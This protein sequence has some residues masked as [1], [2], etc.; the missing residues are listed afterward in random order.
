MFYMFCA[1]PRPRY[2]VS[3]YRTNGSLVFIILLVRFGLLSGH[4][5][6]N[7]C[8]LGWPYVLSVLCLFLFITHFGFKSGIWRLIALVPVHCFSFICRCKWWYFGLSLTKR[9]GRVSIRG[10]SV[11]LLGSGG[12]IKALQ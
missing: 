10:V 9:H 1:F 6:G 3:V 8:P 7:S 5:L 4:L 12:G 2:Q 11:T